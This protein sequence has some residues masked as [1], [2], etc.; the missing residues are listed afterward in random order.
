MHL[1][2]DDNFPVT[3]CTLQKLFGVGLNGHLILIIFSSTPASTT[4]RS[5]LCPSAARNTP[6]RQPRKYPN[7]LAR[8]YCSSRRLYFTKWPDFCNDFRRIRGSLKRNHTHA[9]DVGM[10]S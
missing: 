6:L 3:G 10:T 5:D 4:C 2:A 8:L 9:A 1:H 7:I